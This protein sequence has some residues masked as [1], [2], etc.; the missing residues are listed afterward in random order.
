MFRK[1]LKTGIGV[2]VLGVVGLLGYL[3][4]APPDLL[5]VGTNYSAKIVCSNVFIAGRDPEEVLAVDVQAPGHPL[6]K[7]VSIEVDREAQ[8]VHARLFRFFA[9]ATSQFRQGLGCTNVHAKSLSAL[10]LEAAKPAPTGL[11][12]TGNDVA[13][14]QDPKI[15][16]VLSDDTL[17]GEGYRA[18]VVVQGGRIVAERYAE[19]FDADTPLLG[20]SMT[21][22][23]TAGLI[24]TLINAGQ[25]NVSD[26]LVDSFPEWAEDA[27][28]DITVADML[29]MTS[30]LQWNEEYGDVSDVTRMLYLSNDMAVFAAD[31]AL[32]AGIGTDFNY[33]S[34]T[35][36]V[37]SRVW[38]DKLTDGGFSYPRDALFEPLGMASAIIETDV[39]DTFIGSS[40]MYAT[41][42][43]WAKYGQFLLQKGVWDGAQILPTGFVDW[44]FEPVAASGGEYAKGQLWL[45]SPGDLPPF[46]DAVWLQGHDGQ[47]IGIFP[48]RDM[49]V[50]RMGLTPS[51]VGYSSLPLAKALIAAFGG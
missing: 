12:P 36:T 20:W 45:K 27:R 19:G 37:L 32:E 5:K 3:L 35:S 13:Q 4:I 41:A 23:V 31:R 43:D 22:T 44:M 24:G 46:E 34:G 14:S 26:T 17:L 25:M 38:Q 8:T 29:A 33:S 2:A 48:S 50:V 16:A 18:V 11:W 7:H 1:V 9:P 40:Y 51:R 42:R 10:G 39:A 6:L 15:Q 30:G 47:S 49:V 28:R 21:K